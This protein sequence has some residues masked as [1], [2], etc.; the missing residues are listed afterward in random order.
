MHGATMKIVDAQQAKM[1][2]I[3]KSTKLKLLKLLT[4]CTHWHQYC[5]FSEAQIW[6]PWWWFM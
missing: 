4:T 3:Y 1:C 6:A 2:N 5:N